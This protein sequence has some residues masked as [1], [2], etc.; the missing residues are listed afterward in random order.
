M[1]TTML[2]LA[3]AGAALAQDRGTERQ[4]TTLKERLGLSE[5]QTTKVREIFAKEQADRDK[6][7][8]ERVAKIKELLTD[9]QKP[10]YDEL[11]AQ[12]GR[13]GR[14]GAAPGGFGGFGNFGRGNQ[15][16]LENLKTELGL[17]DEQVEKIKP[18]IDEQTAAMTKRM[19]ELRAQGFQGLDWQAELGKMQEA[20]KSSSDRIKVHLN[21][22]QKTKL[23]AQIERA[24]A[25]F[26]MI[27]GLAQNRGGAPAVASRPS[28]E[29]RVRR[30]VDALKIEKEDERAA[31]R[32]LIEKVVKAQDALEDQGKS[33]RDRAGES[34]RNAELSEQALEDRLGEG[35]KERRRLEKE[36]SDLQG[37]LADVVSVRQE[38]ELVQQGILR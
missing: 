32:S 13:G 15:F 17:T 29:E 31:V 11:R 14:G 1:K 26:R 9:E 5:E 23:D 22:E 16:Q 4:V 34:A 20:I 36:L 24:T 8:E 33:S 12:G 7:D 30:A 18:I 38:A 3:M 27:P 6:L 2:W 35:R 25:M 21:D 28:A 19:E 37:Q 10:K